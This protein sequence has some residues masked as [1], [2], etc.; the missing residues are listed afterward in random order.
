MI[1]YENIGATYLCVNPVFDSWM[2]HL[3]VDFYFV[4]NLVQDGVLHVTHVFSYDKL[5]DPFNQATS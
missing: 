2:K 3:A 4:H 5:A 1:Y